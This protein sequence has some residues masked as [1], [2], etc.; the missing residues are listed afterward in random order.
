MEIKSELDPTNP[1]P[2]A[3][4]QSGGNIILIFILVIISLALGAAGLLA[5]QKYGGQL[6]QVPSAVSSSIPSQAA[7][8]PI[9][10]EVPTD[11]TPTPNTFQAPGD[12]KTYKN[13]EFGLSFSYP[14]NFQ[15]DTQ[16]IKT[17]YYVDGEISLWLTLTQN[18]YTKMAQNPA[19]NLK[20]VK[21][22]NT[23]E[24]MLAFVQ[25][26]NQEG[27]AAMQD[28][29]SIGYGQK[30]PKINSTEKVLGRIE[31]TKVD[32]YS[33]PGAP[34]ANLLEYYFKYNDHIFILSA[35]FGTYNSDLKQ[36]G[37][38]EKELLPQIL[39]TFKFPN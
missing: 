20:I 26:K 32:R 3:P 1:I 19:I 12:W 14:S 13:E 17:D 11:V 24:Q 31:T 36:D 37:T 9:L 33:G 4:R 18:I 16:P 23:V 6:T 28:P 30:P 2:P 29:Q 10:T 27:E 5:Y 38:I 35:N 39:F 21:T 8:T 34:N 25:Q 15:I 22:S 7:T